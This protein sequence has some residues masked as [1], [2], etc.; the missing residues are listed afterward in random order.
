MQPGVGGGWSP[1]KADNVVILNVPCPE[2]V[3]SVA[4]RLP[5][6]KRDFEG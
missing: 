4:V 6:R 3:T 5:Y 1:D 2:N